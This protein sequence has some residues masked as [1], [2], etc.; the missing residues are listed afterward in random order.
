MP[1][2]KNKKKVVKKKKAIKTKKQTKEDAL[3]L[4]KKQLKSQNK[5][6]KNILIILAVIVVLILAGYFYVQSQKYFDYKGIEFK[7]TK[8]GEGKNIILFYETTTFLEPNDG[9][10][11]PFGFRMRTKPSV[12]KRVN[13]ENL[14]DFDLLKVNGYSYEEGTFNCQGYGVIAMENLKRVFNKTGMTFVHDPAETCDPQ[15]RYNYFN[16]KYG[17]KTEIK[18]VGVSCYDVIIKGNDDECEILKATEKLM[19][20][21]FVKYRDI[22]EGS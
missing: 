7:T 11:V 10:E 13:F 18:Q 17:D 15:G 8:I 1:K 6:L 14:E 9:T 5:I 21:I 2:E 20:E 3:E 4:T 16:I 19:V 12:L 22:L